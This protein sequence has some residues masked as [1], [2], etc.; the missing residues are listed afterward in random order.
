MEKG[1]RILALIGIILLAALYGLT[2]V[3]A[4]FDNTNT[5]RYLA[6]S[7]MATVIVPVFIWVYQ[8]IYRMIRDRKDHSGEVK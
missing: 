3:A 8:L 5:M 4:I 7:L 1:K 2:I 6:A